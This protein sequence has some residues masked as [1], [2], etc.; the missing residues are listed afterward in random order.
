MYVW[1]G[2]TLWLP[3]YLY[4]RIERLRWAD[5][6]RLGALDA[7]DEIWRGAF[8][9]EALCESFL[10]RIAAARAESQRVRISRRGACAAA[11]EGADD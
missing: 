7:R 1:P 6:R 10:Q 11:G 3:N 5:A 8:S 9:A 4:W 2:M